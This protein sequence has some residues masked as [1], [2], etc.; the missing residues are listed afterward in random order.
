MKLFTFYRITFIISFLVLLFGSMVKV[1]PEEFEG[2][3]GET[4]LLGGFILAFI[5]IV[6][7]FLMMFQ[8]KKMSMGERLIWVILFS[9]G[10]I[11]Q[12][13][14]ILFIVGLIFLIIGNKRL[15]HKA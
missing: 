7:A 5:Y 13:P 4:I 9:V 6:I 11:F 12:I 14:L 8:S 10:L 15:Q 3:N 2:M 1:T